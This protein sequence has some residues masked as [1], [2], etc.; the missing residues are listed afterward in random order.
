MKNK[1]D[2]LVFG[3]VLL[4]ILA[5]IGFKLIKEEAHKAPYQNREII[6]A[7]S[8]SKPPKYLS[9][10]GFK[11]C[12]DLKVKDTYSVVCLPSTKPQKCSNKAWQELSKLNMEKC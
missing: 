9:I 8:K 11:K 1:S 3:I 7:D 12:I 4:V 10:E 2:L 5:V 6:G